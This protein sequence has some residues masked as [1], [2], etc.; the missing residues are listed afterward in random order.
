MWRYTLS[1]FYVW[2]AGLVLMGALAQPGEATACSTCFSANEA[3]RLAYYGTTVGLSLLPL[4]LVAGLGYWIYRVYF[5][6]KS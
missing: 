4:A 6:A 5:K 3:G 1:N 2:F